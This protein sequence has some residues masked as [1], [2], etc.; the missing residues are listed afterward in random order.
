MINSE[1]FDTGF[2]AVHADATILLL[3]NTDSIDESV[4]QQAFPLEDLANAGTNTKN[5]NNLIFAL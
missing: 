2:K 5:I 3:E 4:K 1:E